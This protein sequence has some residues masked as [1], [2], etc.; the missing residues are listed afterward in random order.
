MVNNSKNRDKD[1]VMNYCNDLTQ[2]FVEE[3]FFKLEA[4]ERNGFIH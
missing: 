3:K 2:D 1:K 4:L